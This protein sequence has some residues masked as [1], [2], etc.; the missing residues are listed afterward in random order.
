[1]QVLCD[2]R[3]PSMDPILLALGFQY[4]RFVLLSLLSLNGFLRAA[5]ILGCTAFPSVPVELDE[6]RY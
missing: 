6:R 1:M 3:P 2:P 4:K 5:S